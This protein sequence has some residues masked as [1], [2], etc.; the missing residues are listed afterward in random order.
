V[1]EGFGATV[2]VGV[3]DGGSGSG[4]E[5]RLVDIANAVD[6]AG[7][8]PAAGVTDADWRTE[9]GTLTCAL[10]DGDLSHVDLAPFG[11]GPPDRQY[12][13]VQRADVLRVQS[14]ANV[15]R[16]CRSPF[17]DSPGPF[18]VAMRSG[19]DDDVVGRR[20]PDVVCSVTSNGT[21]APAIPRRRRR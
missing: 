9:A 16:S 10:T 2:A 15:G 8:Q 18:A 12:D 6:T 11:I 21:V 19:A 1:S 4:S 17:T 5:R 13:G 14:R 20:R 7:R 3:G